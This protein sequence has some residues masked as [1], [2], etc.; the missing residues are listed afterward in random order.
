[1]IVQRFRFLAVLTIAFVLV[2]VV[3][4]HNGYEQQ[5]VMIGDSLSPLRVDVARSQEQRIL[6]LSGRQKLRDGE[7][8]LFVY[9]SEQ[10]L[11]FWMK[12]MEFA[13]DIIWINSHKRVLGVERSVSPETFPYVYR[14]SSPAQYVLEVSAGYAQLNNINEG[15][16][17]SF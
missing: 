1:M 2:A 8:M 9:E 7:G 13:I 12:D 11:G 6:G 15:V 14:P 10:E 4:S 5:Y 16:Q 17:L 3:Q